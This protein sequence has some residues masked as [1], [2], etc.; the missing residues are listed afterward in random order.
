[1]KLKPIEIKNFSYGTVRIVDPSTQGAPLSSSPGVTS[2]T[3]VAWHIYGF[4]IAGRQSEKAVAARAAEEESSTSFCIYLPAYSLVFNGTYIPVD[5]IR[6]QRGNN[7]FYDVT[8]FQ[9]DLQCSIYKDNNNAIRAKLTLG[10]LQNA[11][12]TF[13]V[14]SIAG[15]EKGLSVM[16]YASGTFTLTYGGKPFDPIVAINNAQ[17]NVQARDASEPAPASTILGYSNCYW[18]NGGVLQHMEDQ[19]SPGDDGFIALRAGATSSTSG[20]ASLIIKDT[21]AA[22]QEEMQDPAYFVMP[23]YKIENGVITVDFR[24]TPQA[25]VAEVL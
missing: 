3:K 19:Q 24:S 25:Q 23:L 22:L 17:Q 20:T 9:G 21:F 6:G 1:M 11:I 16:Q 7:D 14:C 5:P 2:D 15:T 4:S 18:M 13:T 10:P 12:Y 8:A